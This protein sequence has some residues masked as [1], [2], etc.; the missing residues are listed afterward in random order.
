MGSVHVH[1]LKDVCHITPTDGKVSAT[2]A[3]AEPTCFGNYY[4]GIIMHVVF[5]LGHSSAYT[6]NNFEKSGFK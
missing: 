6:C 2:L 3:R 5:P 1:S 4:Y